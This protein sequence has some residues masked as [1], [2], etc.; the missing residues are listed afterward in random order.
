MGGNLGEGVD[1]ACHQ[2]APTGYAADLGDNAALWNQRCGVSEAPDSPVDH[3]SALIL[4][5][6]LGVMFRILG[7]IQGI[8]AYWC[9]EIFN[10]REN[11]AELWNLF[12]TAGIHVDVWTL[13]N[14]GEDMDVFHNPTISSTLLGVSA[15][16]KASGRSAER[17]PLAAANRQAKPA[18][19]KAAPAKRPAVSRQST[20]EKKISVLKSLQTQSNSGMVK[21]RDVASALDD[22]LKTS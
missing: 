9:P 3:N 11:V 8:T 18:P 7:I 14:L 13:Q 10:L 17:K 6:V 21:M 22:L 2:K 12:E 19:A 16:Q 5:R 15:Y 1:N 4:P 20:K